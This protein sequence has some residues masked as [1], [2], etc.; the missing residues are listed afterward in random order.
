MF[1]H[2]FGGHISPS[3]S[4]LS[5]SLSISSTRPIVLDDVTLD[6]GV[7]DNSLLRIFLAFSN[8]ILMQRSATKWRCKICKSPFLLH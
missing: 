6:R 3:C 2:K 5:S 4:S 1:G 7:L 8:D